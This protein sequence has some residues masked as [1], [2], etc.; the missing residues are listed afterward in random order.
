MMVKLP[1]TS[2]ANTTKK[3]KKIEAWKTIVF[4]LDTNQPGL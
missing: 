3:S 1:S 4:A 2:T